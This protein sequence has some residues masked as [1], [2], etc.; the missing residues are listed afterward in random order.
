MT[1]LGITLK[2]PSWLGLAV[3]IVMAVASG[4]VAHALGG[5][6]LLVATSV[7]AGSLS[8][9][10]G[11]SLTEQGWRGFVLFLGFVMLFTGFM[12]L[13]GSMAGI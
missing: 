5:D 3:V 2:T 9:V 11:I 6:T 4:W 13:V 1:L 7:A 8:S 10:S 12:K